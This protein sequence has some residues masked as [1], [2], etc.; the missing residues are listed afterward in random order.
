MSDGNMYYER[1][2]IVKPRKALPISSKRFVFTENLGAQIE[3]VVENRK[4]IGT[5]SWILNTQNDDFI[6]NEEDFLPMSS[7]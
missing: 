5:V 6:L 7:E 4:I 3:V 2:G 1:E